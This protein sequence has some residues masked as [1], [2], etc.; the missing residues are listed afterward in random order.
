L[1]LGS[2]MYRMRILAASGGAWAQFLEVGQAGVLDAVGERPSQL[3]SCFQEQAD[4]LTY[5]DGAGPVAM[6]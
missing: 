5:L 1:R 2:K 4:G 3:G 6:A